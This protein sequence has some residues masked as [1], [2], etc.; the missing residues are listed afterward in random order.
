MKVYARNPATS[1]LFSVAFK[2][3]TA[4]KLPKQID[5]LEPRE[6]NLVLGRD[7]AK[8]VR[9]FAQIVATEQGIP[10]FSG[11]VETYDIDNTRE[12]TLS[13][14]GMEALLNQRWAHPYFYPLGTKFEDLF[15]SDC[16]HLAVPGLLAQANSMLPPGWPWE[17]HDE[18]TN[19][20]KI[21]GGGTASRLGL[22]S[23]YSI[24]YRYL[25]Q[26]DESPSLDDMDYVDNAYWRDS[27]DLYIK[28]LNHYQKGW[29]DVGGLMIDSA[30][31]T[32]VRLGDISNEKTLS[33]PLQTNYDKIGDLIVDIAL[34]HGYYVR[35]REDANFVTYLDLLDTEGR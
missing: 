10:F 8:T 18:D 34:G 17:Y 35:F 26:V 1:K 16:T 9:Q 3:E 32:H 2:P 29:P 7:V 22:N 24:D 19:I 23:I 13:C 4:L 31:D 30:F 27:D 6:L 11:Y 5:S 28:L 25:R 21:S 14:K 20:V 12:K 15:S 33:G